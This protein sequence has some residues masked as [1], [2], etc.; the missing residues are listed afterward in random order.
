[1]PTYRQS[2]SLARALDILLAQQYQDWELVVVNDGSPDDTSDIVKKYRDDPR[3]RYFEWSSN[4]GIGEAL[5]FATGKACGEYIAYLPSDDVYYPW[6]LGDLECA[7]GLGLTNDNILTLVQVLHR[8]DL[9]EHVRWKTRSEY[10]SDYLE[11]DFWY[12]LIETGAAF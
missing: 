11:P 4:Q 7:D 6:H 3:V 10:V 9:E 12:S 2:W 8:R 1:M 5:N